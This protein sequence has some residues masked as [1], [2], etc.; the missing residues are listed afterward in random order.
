MKIAMAQINPTIADISGNREKIISFIRDG[1]A[2]GANLVIFPEMATIGYPPMDLLENRKLINDNLASIEEIARHCTGTAVICG[3]VDQDPDN[4]PLLFNAAA[5]MAGGKIVSRHFKTL[6][7]AYDV[8]DELRYFSRARDHAVVEFMG[9]RIGITIC[10]D[11]WNDLDF[12]SEGRV[13]AGSLEKYDYRRRYDIDPIQKLASLKADLVVNISASPFTRGKNRFKRAMIADIAR[14][15]ALPVVY[16]NQVGGNDSLVFD[17]NSVAFSSRGAVIGRAKSFEE[18]LAIADIDSSTAV[19]TA[20]SDIE[21]IRQALVLGIRDYVRKCGFRS[22][23]I[24]LSGGIDSALTAALAVQALGPENVTGITMPSAYSSAGSVDDSR[25]LAENLDIRF[26]TIPI[27]F[28]F[29]KFRHTLSEIFRGRPEDVTEENIQ[30]RIRGNILMAV[31][32]KEKSLV[33]STGNKSEL[34]MGYCTLYG[35]MSGGLAVISDL[36]KTLVYELSRHINRDREIIP[37]AS[38]TKPPSAELRPG[39][40]DQDSLP[41][42]EVLDGILELYIEDRLSADEIIA[43]GFPAD[44]VRSVL[45]TVNVNEYKRRQAA[46]GIKVTAKA[47]GVGRRIPIAQRFRP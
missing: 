35:D 46:P 39:Q 7:P 15:H 16:V 4:H 34:A 41:P 20:D 5:F 27:R 18:D 43:R 31:S 22:V 9:R 24:G 38:I 14:H 33:L 17:G 23:V 1:A 25:A 2:R 36:P 29:D 21:E 19:G 32:N 45:H 42:Y 11:I 3:Y 44:T 40:K 10:E 12:Y 37:D 13:Q 47:F 30:A 26:E 8:F 28:L 6:L